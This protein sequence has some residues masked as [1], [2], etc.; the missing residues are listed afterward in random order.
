MRVTLAGPGE[1]PAPTRELGRRQPLG[2]LGAA[3][4]SPTEKDEL[5]RAAP[6]FAM[7]SRSEGL[8]MALLEAMAYGMA[9]VATEVGGIPEVFDSGEDG[10]LVPPEEPE[11]LA[12][13]LC[14]LAADP[15]LRER[16][17]RAARRA[18]ERLDAVEV[19]GRLDAL[20]AS[21]A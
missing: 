18:G 12:G 15:E 11:A 20:Y 10:V 8:P 21:L 14:R 2:R 1:L 3:G 5:L 9:I 13:A 4:S 16:L 7:P 19:A 6:V 17:A